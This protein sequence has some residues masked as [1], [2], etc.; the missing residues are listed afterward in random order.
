MQRQEAREEK[1]H[2]PGTNEGTTSSSKVRL[3]SPKLYTGARIR[4][5]FG[6]GSARRPKTLRVYEHDLTPQ[7]LQSLHEEKILAVDTETGGLD[8]RNDPL[9]LVQ[10]CTQDGRVYMIRKPSPNSSRLKRLL[11][12]EHIKKIFHHAM[13]DL[14]FLQAQL[15]MYIPHSY[16]YGI[17][18]TKTLMKIRHPH[19]A[20]GLGSALKRILE[21]KVDKNISHDNWDAEELD[22]KQLVYAANDVL[23][24]HELHNKLTT[25]MGIDKH[26]TYREAMMGI[27][28]SARLQVQGYTDL[29]VYAKDDYETV[30]AN[31]DWWQS[32]L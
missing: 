21:V 7:A 31:R 8:Y 16:G 10:I 11:A 20:S 24:L 4:K 5:L 1:G 15:T 14:R 25:E 22:P 18:C 17:H 29:L 30:K 27:C 2:D 28:I 23:Y 12:N 13:F 19:M 32:R 26:L 6:S 9:L 3:A